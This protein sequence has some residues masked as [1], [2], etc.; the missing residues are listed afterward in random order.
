MTA[1]LR[2]TAEQRDAT[3]VL[4]LEGR[5][6]GEWIRELRRSWRRV[7]DAA[8]AAPIRVELADVQFVDTAGKVLL[9]E[10]HREGVEIIARGCLATA[11]RDEIVSGAG[12]PPSAVTEGRQLSGNRRSTLPARGRMEIK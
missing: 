4:K 5:L 7:R 12:S 11:I 9:A 2:I 10:M 8:A 3:W 6:Q 1:M